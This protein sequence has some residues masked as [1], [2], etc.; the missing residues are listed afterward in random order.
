MRTSIWARVA[1]IGL[2]AC[3]IAALAAPAS[4]QILHRD[5]SKAVPFV[6]QVSTR[7][8]GTARDPV[9]RRDGSKAVPFV[10]DLEPH[11]AAPSADGFHWRDA[12]IGAGGATIALLAIVCIRAVRVR[13]PVQRRTRSG[14][15]SS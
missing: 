11:L 9:L 8:D 13:V 10:A 7:A 5:G 15:A 2:V 14:A 12:A 3:T 6:S 1:G 4:G